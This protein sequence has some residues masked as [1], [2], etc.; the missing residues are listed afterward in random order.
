MEAA[1]EFTITR[2]R[3]GRLRRVF[4]WGLAGVFAS[5]GPGSVPGPPVWQEVLDI[6][7]RSTGKVVATVKNA[8][9]SVF[10]NV[11]AT[12]REFTE[13]TAD[14]FRARWVADTA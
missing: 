11:S 13:L 2:R 7:R 10:D 14:E 8:P 6:R 5:G 4:S 9:W 12:E 3:S 1:D